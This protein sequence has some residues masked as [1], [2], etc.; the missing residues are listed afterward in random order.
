[1]IWVLD[2]KYD[3]EADFRAFYHLDHRSMYRLDGPRFFALATR[4]MAF[5]GV[6]AARAAKIQA[7]QNRRNGNQSGET[8]IKPSTPAVL[9]GD[10]NLSPYIEY[11][12]TPRR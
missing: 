9:Q 11:A 10:A 7:D 12:S 6:M 4:T 2:H 3:L 1:V 5:S 8:R